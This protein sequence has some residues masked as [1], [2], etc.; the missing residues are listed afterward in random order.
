MNYAFLGATKFSQG[1]LEA[2]LDANLVPS[3]IFTIPEE[4]SISY[5]DTLVKNSNY[6]DL[7]I[8]ATKYNIPL[9]EIEHGCGKKITEYKEIL[10]NLDLDVS[11]VMGWYYMV[12][13][14]IRELSTHGCWAIHASLLPDY[15]G[16]APLVWAMINGERETGVTLFRLDDGVDSGDIIAQEKFEISSSDNIASM[17]QLSI[18]KSRDIVV[19]AMKNIGHV[20]YKPQNCLDK[21]VYPQRSPK[22]GEIDLTQ[23]S[24]SLYNFIRAQSSPYPG[25]FIR[26]VDGM[27]LVI[28]KAR[29][30]ELGE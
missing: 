16:G 5:S 19:S 22:D 9:Y 23:P 6:A 26:T 30:E 10:C 7:S 1:I 11:L 25:A 27:K 24:D 28:E 4:F 21:R 29:I 8:I 2:L 3:V 18:D 20:K 13:K 14:S 15:S 17:L 12:P